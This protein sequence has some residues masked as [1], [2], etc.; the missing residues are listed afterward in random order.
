MSFET[1]KK[2]KNY[3]KFKKLVTNFIIKKYSTIFT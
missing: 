3:K 2:R 1:E